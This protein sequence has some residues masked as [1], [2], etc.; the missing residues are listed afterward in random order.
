MYGDTRERIAFRVGIIFGVAQGFVVQTRF[1]GTGLNDAV[2]MATSPGTINVLLGAGEF[3]RGF[4]TQ[5]SQRRA[6]Q[7]AIRVKVKLNGSPCVLRL[8]IDDAAYARLTV[9]AL[10]VRLGLNLTEILGHWGVKATFM[11]GCCDLIEGPIG[12]DISRIQQKFESDD[13][14]VVLNGNDTQRTVN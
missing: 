8:D 14:Q 5:H 7:W 2:A 4:Y 6:L 12:G 1:H 11:T 9:L 13:A 10:D 3:G